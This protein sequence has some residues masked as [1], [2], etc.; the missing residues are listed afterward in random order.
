MPDNK[1]TVSPGARAA[2]CGIMAALSCVF[3]LAAF[4]PAGK[5]ALPAIAGIVI[6]PA[7]VELGIR[8]GW[9]SYAA[10]AAVTL[11]LPV[12]IEPKL[13]YI[14]FFGY[15][16]ILK[17]GIESRFSRHVEWLI[18]F[19]VFNA[20][21]AASY[22]L[23]AKVFAF[24]IAEMFIISGFSVPWLILLAGNAVFVIFDIA[25][26]NILSAYMRVLSPVF[27]KMFR[28]K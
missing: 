12:G 24:D 15:Y 8:S 21:M 1:K 2:F 20:A 28:L 22:T 6:V 9:M 4:I 18:K 16:P 27:R 26:T 11:I 13:L 19:A 7:V 23:L 3:M 10:A 17:A 14:L 5:Y 25:I